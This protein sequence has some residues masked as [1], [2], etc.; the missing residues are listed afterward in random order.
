MSFFRD[1]EFALMRAEVAQTL[2]G[3]A[4]IQR[5]TMGTG[6]YGGETWAAVGTVAARLDPYNRQ[7]SSGQVSMMEAGRS[8]YQ[9]TLPYDAD[10]QDGDRVSID[11]VIYEAV[12]VHSRQTFAM[13]TRSIV[14][15]LK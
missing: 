14:A 13:A 1:D 5:M 12:Q 6:L 7:D 2:P 4:V 3:T 10:L 8:Y 9:L 11:N 15:V